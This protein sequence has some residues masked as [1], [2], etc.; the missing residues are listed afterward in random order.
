MQNTFMETLVR[1]LGFVLT[2]HA[3][4]DAERQWVSASLD[5]EITALI[6]AGHTDT[7]EMA[8]LAVKEAVKKRRKS[9]GVAARTATK[10]EEARRQWRDR[11]KNGAA[12]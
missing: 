1:A 11:Q 2:S 6:A 10:R 4:T 5:A 9:Q 8:K 3:L 7:N 12:L